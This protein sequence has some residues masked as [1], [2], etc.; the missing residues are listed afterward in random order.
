MAQV[1]TLPRAAS[2]GAGAPPGL[3]ASISP[4]HPHC[5]AAAQHS[6]T[7]SPLTLNIPKHPV[8]PCLHLESK[9]PAASG[10]FQAFH[11][12][13][14]SPHVPFPYHEH[15]V[16]LSTACA[17]GPLCL[18]FPSHPLPHPVTLPSLWTS[19]VVLRSGMSL[20]MKL[21]PLFLGRAAPLSRPPGGSHPSFDHFQRMALRPSL[22]YHSR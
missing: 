20:L 11:N 18:L 19:Y 17:P 6:T 1:L 7:P 21:W 15:S 3:P 10:A 16:S 9:V 13:H 8:P 2:P 22:G 14:H 4:S 5:P 12:L